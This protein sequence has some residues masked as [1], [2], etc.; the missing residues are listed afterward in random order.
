MRARTIRV[1]RPLSDALLRDELAA[2][3]WR[4]DLLYAFV[5][6]ELSVRYRQA[7]IGVLWVVL[8]PRW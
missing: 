1:I 2:L 3:S 5:R 6:R 8:Q 7:V 4:C